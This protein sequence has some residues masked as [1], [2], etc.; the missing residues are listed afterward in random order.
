MK[1]EHFHGRRMYFPTSYIRPITNRQPS[2]ARDSA[3]SGQPP[4]REKMVFIIRQTTSFL[5]TTSDAAKNVQHILIFDDH[6]DS[7][8]LVLGEP[9]KPYANHAVARHVTSWVLLCSI[10]IVGLLIAMF[11]PLF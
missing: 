1:R 3:P 8:R 10:L 7:L 6:P 9:A 4:V 5:P 11:W 2:F